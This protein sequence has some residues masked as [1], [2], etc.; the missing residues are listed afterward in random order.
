M[1]STSTLMVLRKWRWVIPRLRSLGRVQ[2]VK[3]K[4]KL[5]K[6]KQVEIKYFINLELHG[7]LK[8][9]KLPKRVHQESGKWHSIGLESARILPSAHSPG[10]R[11]T[12]CMVSIYNKSRQQGA[13]RP[14]RRQEGRPTFQTL[15]LSRLRGRMGRERCWDPHRSEDRKWQQYVT[16][17]FQPV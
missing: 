9:Y 1:C 3:V 15:W 4:K 8:M 6:H 11:S 5:E 10:C 16:N 17:A 13:R 12:D 2:T 14:Q 7:E